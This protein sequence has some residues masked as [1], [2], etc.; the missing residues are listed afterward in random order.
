MIAHTVTGILAGIPIALGGLIVALVVGV[1]ISLTMEVIADKLGNTCPVGGSGAL[2][3]PLVAFIP[4]FFIMLM[5]LLFG[6]T[7][8]ALFMAPIYGLLGTYVVFGVLSVVGSIFMK[9]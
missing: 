9:N 6:T 8:W 5:A 1:V 7:G 4:V 2:M 3:W